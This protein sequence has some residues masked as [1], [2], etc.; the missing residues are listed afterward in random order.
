M[1]DARRALRFVLPG[2][3]CVFQLFALEHLLSSNGHS[4]W[5]QLWTDGA[6]PLANVIAIVAGSGA[7]G[8][9]LAAVYHSLRAGLNHTD[10][11]VEAVSSGILRLYYQDP[12]NARDELSLS[13]EETSRLSRAQTWAIFTAIWHAR[14]QVSP[15]LKEANARTDSLTNLV[16]SVG[17]L[18]V[19]TWLSAV[20]LV[21]TRISVSISASSGQVAFFALLAFLLL[22]QSVSLFKVRSQAQ[23]TI[24]MILLNDLRGHCGKRPLACTGNTIEAGAPKAGQ[25]EP[26]TWRIGG[27]DGRRRTGITK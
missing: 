22:F 8:F 27:A 2:L 19:G 16:H 4:L 24:D 7:V 14:L 18:Y 5:R 26:F 10:M 23:S 17:T 12:A 13:P 20:F 25:G 6:N 21:L 3:T 9:F 1:D 15:F 11:L